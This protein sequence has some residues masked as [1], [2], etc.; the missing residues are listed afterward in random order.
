MNKDKINILILAL[1][2]LV[3]FFLSWR[4]VYTDESEELEEANTQTVA[5]QAVT[6]DREITSVFAPSQVIL[7]EED[8][9]LS[10]NP[11]DVFSIFN[12]SER[13][14]S[15]SSLMLT[16]DFDLREA[17]TQ[18]S[19]TLFFE[20]KIPFDLYS[21][22][23]DDFP[24]EYAEE[25]FDMIFIPIDDSN[26]VFFVDLEDSTAYLTQLEDVSSH[27]LAYVLK[28]E[29]IQTR[30]E[31][32]FYITG[33]PFYLPVEEVNV[34]HRDFLVEQLPN[35]F[36]VDILFEDT[37]GV[38]VR[39]FEDTVRYTDYYSELYIN[40]VTHI[41]T[42]NRQSAS[43]PETSMN[44]ILERSYRTLL[45]VENWLQPVR[46]ENYDEEE[47]IA[48]FRRYVQGYP[49]MGDEGEGRIEIGVHN[50]TLYHLALSLNV[51]QTPID[52]QETP[53]LKTLENGYQIIDILEN[54]DLEASLINE[55]RI[56]LSWEYSEESDRIVHF[57]PE[58]YVDYNGG[59]YA[60]GDFIN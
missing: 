19:I 42:Y 57:V 20:E 29:S 37:Y 27:Y 49:V 18:S 28:D 12:E 10:L 58:W 54:V 11:D 24:G 22:V 9:A 31:Q 51:A 15:Y 48:T 55:I 17:M 38:E 59:W 36:F 44:S 23:F 5:P 21:D 60:L 3:S 53:E 13:E 7:R 35:S 46:F 26:R 56:G 47:R 1:L 32:L 6:F 8:H 16:E 40:E 52:L 25:T 14:L 50:K 39:H 41:L 4:I 43:S 45:Q 2:I 34:P 30:V 33:R